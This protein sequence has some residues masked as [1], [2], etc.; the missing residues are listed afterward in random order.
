MAH[1][2][3]TIV[4]RM[5]ESSGLTISD[6]ADRLDK[7]PS[8]VELMI[9]G[10]KKP[11]VNELAILATV[12]GYSVVFERGDDKLELAP[13]IIPKKAGRLVSFEGTF[14]VGI[15][16]RNVGLTGDLYGLTD[17]SISSLIK[18]CGANYF[19]DFRKKTCDTLII[20]DISPRITTSSVNNAEKWGYPTVDYEDFRNRYYEVT[21][22]DIA[23]YDGE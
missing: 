21:G 11:S 15:T 19:P 23:T 20:G 5:I 18:S 9:E 6:V 8:D 22:R 17:A 2:R 7:E 13:V 14:D 1:T 10:R 4:T 12:C 3:K 16:G